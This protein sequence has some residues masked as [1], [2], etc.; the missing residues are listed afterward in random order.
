MFIRLD[1]RVKSIETQIKRQDPEEHIPRK[2]TLA[3]IDGN[4]NFGK[5]DG[6][7]QFM[8]LTV[9]NIQNAYG[10]QHK[11]LQEY[12]NRICSYAE[13]LQDIDVVFIGTAEEFP[14]YCRRLSHITEDS[15]T[16]LSMNT[17]N[18]DI[19]TSDDLL[20]TMKTH[21]S[22]GNNLAFYYDETEDAK[23]ELMNELMNQLSKLK[24]EKGSR[25][26]D[27]SYFLRH[28]YSGGRK[29]H[30]H[31]FDALN[32]IMQ[33]AVY[34]INCSS[35]REHEAHDFDIQHIE[36]QLGYAEGLM[37]RIEHLI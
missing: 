6:Y 3:V 37:K 28:M 30:E 25:D 15:A 33:A 23:T 11:K 8:K 35:T 29:Y 12:I 21:L 34:A 31:V 14:A 13:K 9:G 16:I 32:V 10:E 2:G 7:I 18:L 26:T 17:V 19:V 22:A 4:L 24:M 5:T 36:N 20:P 1:S 27:I